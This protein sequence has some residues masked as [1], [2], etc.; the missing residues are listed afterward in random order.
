MAR[1]LG[2]G[3]R[4][5][6]ALDEQSMSQVAIVGAGGFVGLSLVESLVLG[7]TTDIYPIIRSYRNMAGLANGC[8]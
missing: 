1:Q 4:S 7:G 2:K 8:R 3:G 6:D 5:P